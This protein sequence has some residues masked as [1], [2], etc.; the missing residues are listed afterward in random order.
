MSVDMKPCP[1]CGTSNVLVS[2]PMK[3]H[4]LFPIAS[5]MTCYAEVMGVDGDLT[6]ESARKGWNRRHAEAERDALAARVKVLEAE[7]GHALLFAETDIG[8]AIT[9]IEAITDQGTAHGLRQT[10]ERVRR[11]R[12][13]LAQR[14]GGSGDGSA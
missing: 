11:A 6:C 14:E 9:V 13:L 4:R 12:S 2:P 10:L 1:F 5:C 7:C 3:E 8:A